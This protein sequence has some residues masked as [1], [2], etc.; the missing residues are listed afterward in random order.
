MALKDREVSEAQVTELL[1]KWIPRLGLTE[2]KI[3]AVIEDTDPHEYAHLGRLPDMYR[4][5]IT[6]NSSFYSGESEID[7][8]HL[9]RTIVHELMHIS[10]GHFAGSV[11]DTLNNVVGGREGYALVQRYQDEEERFVDRMSLALVKGFEDAN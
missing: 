5:K 3:I 8:P 1:D 6:I 7:T 10:I 4:A 11:I 2:W 9:E